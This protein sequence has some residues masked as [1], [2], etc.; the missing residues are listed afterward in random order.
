M[1]LQFH[2][3]AVF[4][5]GRVDGGD[6]PGAVGGV[7][8]IFHLLRGHSKR[9]GLIAVNHHVDLRVLDLQIAVDVLQAGK[10]PQFLLEGRR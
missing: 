1:R 4:V 10:L 9:G 6:L 3:D 7:Q 8:R 5:V 2:D